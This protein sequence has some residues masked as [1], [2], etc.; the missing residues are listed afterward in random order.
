MKGTE[1]NTISKPN[2]DV[3]I[4]VDDL[5]KAF[6]HDFGNLE[7]NETAVKK[8]IK[9]CVENWKDYEKKIRDKK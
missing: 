2:G 1:V 5:I 9:A 7:N 8:Y 3:F 6:Y 4:K